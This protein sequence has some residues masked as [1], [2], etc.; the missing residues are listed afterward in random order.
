MLN[1]KTIRN[2]IFSITDN[3]YN[4]VKRIVITILG[5]KIKFKRKI[6][7]NIRY[8]L[9]QSSIVEN[10][11]ENNKFIVLDEN[12]NKTDIKYIIGIEMKMNI[13]KPKSR[14]VVERV[15]P[16]LAYNSKKIKTV[17]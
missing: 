11:G 2:Q 10:N 17:A 15:V 7:D 5:I 4:N 16:L 9:K 1:N 13:N 8:L 12:G 3:Y 14:T 6:I